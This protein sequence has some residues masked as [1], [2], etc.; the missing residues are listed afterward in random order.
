MA[1]GNHWAW[2]ALRLAQA[3]VELCGFF[4]SGIH[5]KDEP[6]PSSTPHS[7]YQNLLLLHDSQSRGR[8][9]TSHLLHSSFLFLASLRS[10]CKHFLLP[11]FSP[12]FCL[13]SHLCFPA[14]WL[15]A[16]PLSQWVSFLLHQS[17]S[18]CRHSLLARGLVCYGGS[19]TPLLHHRTL[20]SVSLSTGLPG[21]GSSRPGT[22]HH[23]S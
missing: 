9:S 23:L 4:P 17:H 13:L 18:T 11:I 21:P 7:R 14:T 3:L 6:K 15:N 12:H 19:P 1:E 2:L 22:S 20:P 16:D 8:E 5:C 10:T